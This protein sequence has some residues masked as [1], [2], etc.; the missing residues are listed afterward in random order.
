[1]NRLRKEFS[2]S[3]QELKDKSLYTKHV[4]D[5]LKEIFNLSENGIKSLKVD[6]LSDQDIEALNCLGY[7]VEFH[8]NDAQ[9]IGGDYYVVTGMF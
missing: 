9:V 6:S 4:D 3:V 1:M 7:T 8:E 2:E 5:I